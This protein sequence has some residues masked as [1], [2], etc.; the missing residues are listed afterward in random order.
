[1]GLEWLRSAWDGTVIDRYT[2]VQVVGLTNVAAI[3]A[4]GL[5][6]LALKSDGTVWAWGYNYDGELGDGTTTTASSPSNVNGLT[7][8]ASIAAGEYYSIALKSDGTVW[9][10]GNNSSGQLG[11]GT[12]TSR[13]TPV[14]VIDLT[15]VTTIAAGEKHNLA[16]SGVP[17]IISPTIISTSPQNNEISVAMNAA[18]SATF[19]E[20][21]DATTIN[22]SIFALK[23]SYDNTVS[24]SVSYRN[25]S[26][27]FEPTHYLAGGT[28]YI[29]TLTPGARDFAGNSLAAAYTWT[30]TTEGTVNPILTSSRP[31]NNA[32]EV[33]V[34]ASIIVTFNNPMDPAT[35]NNASFTV[36]DSYNNPVTGS[37][38]YAAGTVYLQTHG[39]FDNQYELYSD[40]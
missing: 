2:P 28:T 14:Q 15:G 27:I 26:A 19:S 40:P 37:V 38:S 20:G 30:F 31:A 6:S 17:D 9:G 32:A 7:N 16:L 18:V 1:M 22:S 34:D 8:I 33:G 5:H 25:G 10:W 36:K 39:L 13:Y 11:D 29:A 3:A 24:G 12:T 35:V 21:M 23:D 4:G